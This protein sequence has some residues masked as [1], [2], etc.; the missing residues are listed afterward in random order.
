[1]LAWLLMLYVRV[2]STARPDCNEQITCDG[3][4]GCASM[5][6]ML[7]MGLCCAAGQLQIVGICCH[8]IYIH[9]H[10]SHRHRHWDW[11]SQHLQCQLD[12]RPHYP[13]RL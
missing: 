3:V 6:G 10:Y 4:S 9:N 13:G 2:C 1:M 12:Q 5:Q 8:G 7:L 11:H